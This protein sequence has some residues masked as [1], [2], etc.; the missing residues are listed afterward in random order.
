MNNDWESLKLKDIGNIFSGNSINAKIKEEKYSD[1]STGIPYIATKDIS[2]ALKINYNNGIS[3]PDNEIDKFRIAKKG[4]VFICAEGGSAGRK[5]GIINQDVCFVNKLFALTPN[6]KAIG[7]YVFYWYQSNDFQKDF[8]DKMT[9]LIGGVSKSKFQNILI[10]IPP[11]AKQVQIVKTLDKAFETIE[12]A[13]VNIEKNIQNS[14]ELFQSRLNEIFSG[15][16]DGWEE[17][18]FKEITTI[19]GDGLH[20]TPKYSE[21][22]EY[23]F[24]NGN[25]LNNGKITF[26]ENTKR[27]SHEE[28]QKYQ[29]NLN[30]RTVFVSI[31]G[32]LGNVAFYHNEKIILGKSACY[33]N[34]IESINKYFVKYF[35]QSPFFVKYAHAEATGAT[36]KNVSLKTMRELKI[37]LPTETEQTNIVK[38]LD[39]LSKQT[40]QLEK[41]YQQKLDNLEELKK[42][43]LQKAFSGE[44]I[45]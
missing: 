40:K 39:I 9:G 3:I 44:L 35:L 27:V 15:K 20:G 25:N 7:K 18:T 45:P 28:Y 6:E 4:S 32:T 5:L 16:G 17:K 31:N 41:H 2:Y 38:E 10:Y 8:Q 21:N 22:G 24:I 36:I 23:Y 29:K 14:K 19:L 11:I 34:L 42:S 1:L 33:F 12:Q 37:N 13:K 30:E 43:I 26:K